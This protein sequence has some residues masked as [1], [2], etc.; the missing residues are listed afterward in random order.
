[1]KQFMYWSAFLYL[2]IQASAFT[3]HYKTTRCMN[4]SQQDSTA[5]DSS[6]LDFWKGTWDAA[7]EEE[8]KP[9]NGRNI[10]SSELNGKVIQESFSILS[11][12]NKG[13]LGRSVSVFDKTD[14]KWKQT[15]VD[16]DGA[17]LDFVGYKKGNDFYFERSF[18]GKNGKLIK[19]RMRFY[20]ITTGSFTWDWETAVAGGPWQ[21]AWRINYKKAK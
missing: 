16:S 15:W 1:M 7:W 20:D 11:G 19:Q 14:G 8:G 3:G 17:Y 21:L 6:S 18:T 12:A 10:I 5:G 9:A 4:L 13:F 2:I